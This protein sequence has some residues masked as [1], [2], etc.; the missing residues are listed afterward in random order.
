MELKIGVVARSKAGRDKH[1]FF[2]VTAIDGR[3]A[4][5]CDGK[6]HLLKRPKKKNVKHL[7]LTADAIPAGTFQTDKQ[8]RK[9]L[10]PYN[11]GKQAQSSYEEGNVCP[12]KMLSK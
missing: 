5:L 3:Y 4:Y 12:N 2:I 9:A 10:F 1:R 6:I 11:Y 7:S 8:I